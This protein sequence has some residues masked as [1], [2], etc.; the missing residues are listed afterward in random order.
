MGR[1]APPLI[2]AVFTLSCGASSERMSSAPSTV[3]GPASTLTGSWTGTAND[4][5]GST[6]VTWTLTQTGSDAT[7]TVKT[8]AVNP[9][10]GSCNSCHRN[11]SGTFIGTVTGSA[12][13]LKMA[14]AAGIDGDPT[15]ACTATMTG[16]ASAD[17]TDKWMVTYS[18][19]DSCE[20]QFLNGTLTMARR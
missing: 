10:D 13:T 19:S 17:G 14:F 8:N 1:V 4:S 2:L 3:P 11:K 9:D 7:G 12:M 15:P 5:Q 6:T 16:T 20:G 18:G